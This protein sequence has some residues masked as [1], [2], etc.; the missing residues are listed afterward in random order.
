MAETENKKEETR[1]NISING[2]MKVYQSPRMSQQIQVL[3]EE[4]FVQSVSMTT[5][6]YSVGQEEVEYDYA[7]GEYNLN[8]D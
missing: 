6:V 8:W 7:S 1:N 5:E 3:L 4:C 2:K